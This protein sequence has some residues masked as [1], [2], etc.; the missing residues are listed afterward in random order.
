MAYFLEKYLDVQE[1]KIKPIPDI[2]WKISRP[3]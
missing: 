3:V 1:R 2:L